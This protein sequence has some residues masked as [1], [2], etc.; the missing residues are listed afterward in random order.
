MDTE[1]MNAFA[2]RYTTA[3][4]SQNAASVAAHFA[5]DGSLKINAG[6]P[7][8]GREAITTS[9]QAFMS[10]FPDMIVQLDSLVLEGE[11]AVYHWTLIGT[12]TGPGGSGKPVR[13]S[14]Y[15]EW[16]MNSDGLI[17]RSLGHFDEA[18]YTRQLQ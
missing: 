17:Q 14:G 11:H 10:A 6:E 12:N 3:W 9:A 5:T 2:N 7:A 1:K 18:E 15:E 13:I 16:T 8:V 4:C